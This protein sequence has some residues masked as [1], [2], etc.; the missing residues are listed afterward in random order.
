MSALYRIDN[1]CVVTLSSREKSRFELLNL[2]LSVG[3]RRSDPFA[4]GDCGFEV[5]TFSGIG[6]LN[7]ADP[8]SPIVREDA[9]GSC[10]SQYRSVAD[11]NR[12][13]HPEFLGEPMRSPTRNQRDNREQA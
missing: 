13:R 9:S 11:L 8:T 6:N 10:P 4:D 12:P 1:V 5:A 3:A 2:R 7:A